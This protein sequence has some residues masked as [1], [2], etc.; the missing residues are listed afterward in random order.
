M[1]RN[2]GASAGKSA[3]G[4]R[5]T[6]SLCTPLYFLADVAGTICWSTERCKPEGRQ[7]LD[8][9]RRL[10]SGARYRR[11]R[12]NF[13]CGIPA[14]PWRGP[15]A[16]PLVRRFELLHTSRNQEVG[17]RREES[18]SPEAPCRANWRALAGDHGGRA[19]TAAA[20]KA[21]VCGNATCRQRMGTYVDFATSY[22]PPGDLLL[23]QSRGSGSPAHESC[24]RGG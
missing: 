16:S 13:A 24:G 21:R 5:S 8:S 9:L 6:A 4:A 22:A 18:G 20:S 17:G 7:S 14:R 10:P 1:S 12:R 11:A 23:P 19:G 3:Y 15:L 2:C